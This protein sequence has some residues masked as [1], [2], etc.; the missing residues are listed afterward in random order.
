VE[1]A[2]SAR[3]IER[4]K[5]AETLP[6]L[7]AL[8]ESVRLSGLD[9]AS[10]VVTRR[11]EAV[12]A[13]SSDVSHLLEALPPLCNIARYG[14]VRGNDADDVT[15]I[16][17]GLLTRASIALPSSAANLA[18]DAARAL[19]GH[20]EASWR[21][22][23][24]IE[25][26]TWQTT[27]SAALRQVLERESSA[28]LVS[29]KCCR[30]LLDAGQIEASEAAVFLSRALSRGNEAA[31]AGAWIEGFLAGAGALLIHDDGL[32]RILDGWMSALSEE[33][34]TETLPLLRRTF[35]TFASPERRALLERARSSKDASTSRAQEEFDAA[36]AAL[37][38][39]TLA[40]LLGWELAA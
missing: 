3:A 21:A 19:A 20:I 35:G 23:S 28:A 1:S 37:V 6:A 26:A 11:L 31:R 18:E 17:D 24:L 9:E 2:S 32:W 36:R 7:T 38:L 22:L 15:H 33:S 27:M 10:R 39:P 40:E 13:T 14:D 16:I 29:G 30:L 8:L 4:A 12:A 25:S 34:F 5:D